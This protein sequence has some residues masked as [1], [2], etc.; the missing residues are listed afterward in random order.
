[1]AAYRRA[2]TP[3]L[4]ARDELEAA[5]ARGVRR[6]RVTSGAD[7]V[8]GGPVETGRGGRA[9]VGIRSLE[10]N[11]GRSLAGLRVVAGVGLGGK[12]L[13]LGRPV[14]IRDYLGSAEIVHDY[15]DAVAPERI[16][17]VLAVP[18]VVEGDL[19]GLL[20]VASRADV[21][22]TR[23]VVGQ[24][25]GVSR[26]IERDVIVA[27]RVRRGVRALPGGGGPLVV[28]PRVGA[29]PRVQPDRASLRAELDE[30][31]AAVPDPS[32]RRRIAELSARLWGG[33]ATAPRVR[34][35]RADRADEADRA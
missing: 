2:M 14:M 30:A 32:L 15:D 26:A 5:I 35:D 12:A 7:L 4:L 10:G 29:A 20:Y 8:F 16:A 22:L 23:A 13:A 25:V 19:R 9:A 34:T 6:L 24:A 33:E 11:L 18:V 1:M 21:P 3:R 28:P 31:I 17:T 27:E